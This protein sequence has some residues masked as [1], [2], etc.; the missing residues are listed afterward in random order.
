MPL[1]LGITHTFDLP[2]SKKYPFHLIY[3][4]LGMPYI[5]YHGTLFGET[6]VGR[7]FRHQKKNLLLLPDEKFRPIK[8]KVSLNEVQMRL[9]GKQ[10]LETNF[11]ILLG[12]T[13]WAKFSS[14]ET[15]R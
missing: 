11:I 12:K 5:L 2:S 1:I 3:L 7:N 9:R 13:F 15:I 4:I 6:F 14:G 10:V 8:V